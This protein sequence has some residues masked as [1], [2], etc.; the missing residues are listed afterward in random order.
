MG[1]PS[2]IVATDGTL[3][4]KVKVTW[5]TVAGASSYTL[6]YRKGTG[7]WTTVNNVTSGWE[8]VTTDESTFEYQVQANNAVGNS[9]WSATDTGYIA[10]S[11]D[12]TTLQW[13]TS[14]FC[15]VSVPKS[16]SGSSPTLTNATAGAS[17]TA[18]AV[19]TNGTWALSNTSCSVSMNA[20][21]KLTA[22]DGTIEGKVKVTWDDIAGASSYTLQYRKGTGA[23]T[24]VN[25]V[26]SGWEH[27]TTDESDFEYQVWGN[28]ILGKGSVGADTGFIARSCP[29]SLVKWGKG[30]YC[31]A[32]TVKSPSGSSQTLTNATKGVTGAVSAKCN[33]IKGVW[34]LSQ[35]SCEMPAVQ[36]V[37]ASDGTHEDIVRINWTA[38][39]GDGAAYSYD[40]FR[41]GV[42][43]VKNLKDTTFDDAP[44]ERGTV[45]EYTVVAKLADYSNEGKDP[46]HVPACRA[47]R[48]IGASMNADM[49]A[50]NGMIEQWDCLDSV[51]GKTGYDSGAKTATDLAGSKIYKSFKVVI[52]A[53]MPDGDHILNLNLDSVGVVINKNRDYNVDFVLDRASIAVK[54]MKIIYGSSDATEGLTADSVGR[55]GIKLEGG[56]GIGFAEEGR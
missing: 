56:N 18:K 21:G 33:G 16:T 44:P 38:P 42:Q 24:T 10:R 3:Q 14:N 12:A 53:D 23:W 25:N 8:H 6:Q 55:F 15:A 4:G 31:S 30:N 20:P 35:P 9:A 5:G 51:E 49:S 32:N 48:L 17:G 7:A 54:E 28:N 22:T 2:N 47:A 29:A 26:T 36:N 11:C 50:I 46:G 41:D 40:V 37:D 45:Y 27:V 43:I 13:G 52:P 19:C 1:Q 34:E 39:I